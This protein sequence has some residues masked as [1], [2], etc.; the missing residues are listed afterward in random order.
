MRLFLLFFVRLRPVDMLSLH[1]FIGY[2]HTII[3]QH[4]GVFSSFW[5]FHS[6][7]LLFSYVE[8]FWA[9]F[10]HIIPLVLLSTVFVRLWF[11]ISWWQTCHGQGFFYYHTRISLLWIVHC[12]SPKGRSIHYLGPASPRPIIP[13]CSCPQGPAEILVLVCV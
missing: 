13:S 3:K 11:L 12:V 8:P 9:F 7:H 1:I 10:L 5:C 6:R 4:I 2:I